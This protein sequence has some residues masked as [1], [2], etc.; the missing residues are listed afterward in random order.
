MAPT[1]ARAIHDST[2]NLWSMDAM[3]FHCTVCFVVASL[4][5]VGAFGLLAVARMSEMLTNGRR[6]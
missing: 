2:G 3:L 4:M 6:M 5:L 1:P